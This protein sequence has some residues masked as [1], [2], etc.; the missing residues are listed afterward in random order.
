MKN[1]QIGLGPLLLL[2]RYHD[3]DALMTKGGLDVITNSA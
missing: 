1:R 2:T 3:F